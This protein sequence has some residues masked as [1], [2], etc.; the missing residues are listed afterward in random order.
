M[1]YDLKEDE[2]SVRDRA[3][4][5]R[6]VELAQDVIK[7]LLKVDPGQTKKMGV[8]M[9]EYNKPRL[10]LAKLDLREKRVDRVYFLS[11]LRM[12]AKVKQRAMAMIGTYSTV[13]S[14]A[15]KVMLTKMKEREEKGEEEKLAE[16]LPL[17]RQ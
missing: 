10:H 11:E 2:D 4:L 16:E 14:R 3:V 8:F 12:A 15:L 6:R 13:S 5:L 1:L 17:A 9:L 7:Y